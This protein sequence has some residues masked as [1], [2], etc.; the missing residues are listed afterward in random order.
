RV[1]SVA[2]FSAACAST[3]VAEKNFDAGGSLGAWLA[4]W[5]A[6]YLNRTGSIIVILTL[7]VLSII[8][9]TQFSFG[10]MFARASKGSR[11]LSA[12]SV[13]FVRGW[14]DERRKRKQRREVI[15]KHTKKAVGGGAATNAEGMGGQD[16]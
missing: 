5:F 7:I 4:A 16:K 14:L 8:L 10:R 12:R 1:C 2:F 6:D 13:G 15:A 3:H 11:D 9:S